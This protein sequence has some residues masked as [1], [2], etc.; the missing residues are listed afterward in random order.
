MSKFEKL[1]LPGYGQMPGV[2]FHCS[3]AQL[4]ASGPRVLI[5]GGQRQGIQGSM[6]SFEQSSGDGFAL[7]PDSAEGTGPPPPARTQAT[8]TSVGVEPQEK[9][10]L[11]GGFVLNVGCENDLW[12]VAIGLD[13]S[14][15]P[16]PTWE[17]IDAAGE[18]PCQRYGHSATYLHDKGKIVI[19]GGQDQLTQ[20]NDVFMLD[21]ASETWSQPTVTGTP[22]TVRMKH[23]ANAYSK[24]ELFI[25][26]GFNR[27]VDVRVMDDAYKLEVQGDGSSVAWTTLS[28]EAP[29]GSKSIPARAQHAAAVSSSGKFVFIF[30]GYDGAKCLNDFWLVEL[31]TKATRKIDLEAPLPEA[32]SRHTMHVIGDVLH[33]F[34]GFDGSKACSGDIFTLDVSDPA[35]MES[36]GGGEGDGKKKEE[37][38]KDD[39]DED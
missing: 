11:F 12:K 18:P 1:K 32:R 27:A 33:V 15:M 3:D 4:A 31:G 13:V 21:V 38:K 10:I 24:S 7:L 39:D 16:V 25:F 17:K 20:Y 8:L 35:G 9:L 36:G 2:A 14:S 28:L 26:G 37:K 23:T 30:G 22:P 29:A 19:I 34:T 5:F 6:Y